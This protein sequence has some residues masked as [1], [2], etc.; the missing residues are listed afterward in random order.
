MLETKILQLQALT[1]FP[2]IGGSRAGDTKDARSLVVQFLYFSCIFMAKIL[3]SN[4]FLSQT[5]GLVPTL[6]K[7]MDL[8]LPL[9]LENVEKLNYPWKN[10]EILGF[11][12]KEILEKTRMHSSRM[13]TVRCSGHLGGRGLPGGGCVC[14]GGCVSLGVYTSPRGQNS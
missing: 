9:D 8:S 2:L 5:Q 1:G 7:I 6:W 12:I 3:P 14:P 10:P 4:R 11:V 13:R